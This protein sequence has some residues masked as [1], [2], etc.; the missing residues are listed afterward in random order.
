MASVG[1]LSC[2]LAQG[3]VVGPGT[4]FIVDA[5]QKIVL[6]DVHLVR[7]FEGSIPPMNEIMII[8]C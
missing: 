3:S 1:A 4:L 8:S 7:C 5:A 6:C 2:Y